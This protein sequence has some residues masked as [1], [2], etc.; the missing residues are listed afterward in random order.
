MEKVRIVE[1]S[2]FGENKTLCHDRY[3]LH[4]ISFHFIL[5]RSYILSPLPSKAYGKAKN[6]S[7]RPQKKANCKTKKKE[8]QNTEYNIHFMY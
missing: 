7:L 5:F 2:N 6:V 8:P 4:S 3:R 1:T